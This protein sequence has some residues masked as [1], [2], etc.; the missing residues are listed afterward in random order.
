VTNRATRFCRDSIEAKEKF[1]EAGG[2]EIIER[3]A[4]AFTKALSEGHAIYLF[5][6]GG[7][8]ADADHIAGELVGR[9]NIERKGLPA[10]SLASN[11][12][13]MTSLGNDYG[14]QMVFIKQVEALVQPGDVV[15]GLST[16]GNSANII[17]GLS[18]AREIGAVTVSF[19]GR[20]GG[21]LA[22]ICDVCLCV[23]SENTQHVQECYMMAA[24]A[25]CTLVEENLY[26]RRSS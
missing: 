6:N 3:V 12:A 18:L 14:F 23:P 11:A 22:R 5:G 16:S 4:A 1:L 13:V 21:K 15:V 20:T 8:A 9:L 19:T 26:G 17:G 24:H 10:Y 2:S 25:V 7:S